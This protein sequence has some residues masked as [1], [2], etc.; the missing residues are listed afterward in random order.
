MIRRQCA[1]PV[2]A[3]LN[4]LRDIL[5]DRHG[6]AVQAILFY[7]S[8]FRKGDADDGIVDLYLIVDDYRSAFSNRFHAMLNRLLPPNVYY[9]E[10]IFEKKTVRAKY[11]VMSMAD[12]RLGTSMKWFHSYIWGRFA[13]PAGLLYARDDRAADAVYESMGRA[14][15]TFVRRVLPC[16]PQRFDARKLWHQG[17]LLSYR[18]E[19]RA[20]RPAKLIGLVDAA[21]QYYEELTREAM[22]IV[23]DGT[24]ASTA[25]GKI[26][27]HVRI[28]GYQR[29]ANR[30]AW[31]ARFVLGKLLSLLRLFKAI[32]TFKGGVDY[33]LWKIERHSGIRIEVHDRLKKIPL[34]GILTIFWRL[35]RLGAFR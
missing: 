34:A 7:G 14:V 17:L 2:P 26:H 16:L 13:Q 19:L 31:R 18:A 21:P 22:R 5:L 32:S 9:L 8:C 3:A 20:E 12:F 1:R 25:A 24:D 28:A 11:A 4:V 27:Y 35:Y 6:D 10:S 30:F 33:V 23:A 29:L 15:T